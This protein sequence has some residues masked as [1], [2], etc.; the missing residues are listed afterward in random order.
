LVRSFVGLAIDVEVWY[1]TVFGKN[2]DRLLD[3]DI[4]RTRCS[5]CRKLAGFCRPS[6]F[7]R[8]HADRGL[9]AAECRGL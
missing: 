2:R 4:A 3:G 8:R 1:N 6:I 5:I 9:G 7:G